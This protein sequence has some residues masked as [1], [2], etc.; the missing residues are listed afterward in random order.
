MRHRDLG[1]S[2]C[3]VYDEREKGAKKGKAE[4]LGGLL[5]TLSEM[6]GDLLCER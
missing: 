1:T 6:R 2:H 5:G 3:S 4:S